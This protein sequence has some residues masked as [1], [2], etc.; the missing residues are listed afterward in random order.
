MLSRRCNFTLVVLCLLLSS[1]SPNPANAAGDSA[2]V[3]QAV[4]TQ[5]AGQINPT[6]TQPETLPTQTSQPNSNI[7][8]NPIS[9]GSPSDLAGLI[10]SGGELQQIQ[11]DGSVK[12]LYPKQIEALSPDLNLGLT[13]SNGDFWLV[14]LDTQ[15]ITRLTMT[16]N[17][18]ECC[19]T[20]WNNHPDKILFL[21]NTLGG[22]TGVATSGYLTVIKQDGTGYLVLDPDH[23]SSGVPAVSPDGVWIAYGYGETAWL[24]GGEL[25]PQK[26]N[27]V[28]YGLASLK[29]Q[30]ISMPAWS[31]D[32]RYLAWRWQSVLNSGSKVGVLI[33]DLVEKSYRLGT[34][35]SAETGVPELKLTWSP[36]GKWL[37]YSKTSSAQ[38]ESGTYLIQADSANLAEIKITNPRIL[39]QLWSPDGT[40]LVLVANQEPELGSL[41]YLFD[42]ANRQVSRIGLEQYLAGSTLT[43]I[44]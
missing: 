30:T 36:D 28:D 38:E 31:P 37:A 8:N 7:T 40:K 25:G 4:Q 3:D 9:T 22:N 24:F 44:K 5:L 18:V 33:L 23:P 42:L 12:T 26:I 14:K 1:C 41:F 29:G 20:W 43:W 27:P 10:F 15:S 34:L 11:L 2:S 13:N 21:S 19:G 39:P 17:R 35:F 32:G 6:Q 16:E